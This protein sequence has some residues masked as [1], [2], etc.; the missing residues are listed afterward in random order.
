MKHL[1]PMHSLLRIAALFAA[2]IFLLPS[3]AAQAP[4][5]G[6]DASVSLLPRATLRD[7]QYAGS[8]RLPAG[9]FGNS[10]MN[11]S[12]G[13]LVH[14]PDSDSIYVVG[15]A[16]DQAIAQ[17][18][19]PPLSLSS[20]LA[21]LN[22]TGAPLQSFASVLD[23][24]PNGNPQALDRIG[25]LY[26]ADGPA[27]KQL[28]VQAY[29][30]YDAPADN[31]QTTLVLRVASDLAG[32]AVDGFFSIQG[33]AHVSGWITP[34]PQVWQ[35]SLGHDVIAGHAS[36]IAIVSR[37]SLGPSAFGFD[38][39]ELTGIPA[40]TSPIQADALLD[41]DLTSPLAQ[42]LD[43]SS[44]DNDVWTFLSHATY[45][46]VVPSSSTYVTI[47]YSGGHQSGVCYKCTQD[48]GNLCGGYC[49]PLVADNYTYYW[50][51]DMKDL[52]K[53]KQGEVLP[54][55]VRPYAH[56]AFPVPFN[57]KKISGGSFDPTSK[58]LFLTLDR[59]DNEQGQWSNPPVI[60]V[61]QLP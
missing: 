12:Q 9:T 45:G 23:R 31:T 49:T 42:D 43:N 41:F 19:V 37:A 27:G 40:P 5:Q 39:S 14:D 33:A 7:F 10:S 8:F 13:P 18:Q 52:V 59:A 15:H 48:D 29:E 51:W 30:Y 44:G 60:A 53:V 61:Y 50:M 17:F 3:A 22:M 38:L 4:G 35:P 32:S 11:W 1:S 16:H 25:G 54:S 55:K 46:F 6:T 21:E 34:I 58:R 36:G 24:A 28:I 56:G 26:L 20:S 57:T 47:G 2:S